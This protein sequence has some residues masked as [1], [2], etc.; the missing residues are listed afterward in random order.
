MRTFRDDAWTPV[1]DRR[2][3]AMLGR[4]ILNKTGDVPSVMYFYN[5]MLYIFR[6]N[7][8]INCFYSDSNGA[9][10]VALLLEVA[11]TQHPSPG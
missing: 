11:T 5:G 3:R 1:T 4:L 6:H 2:L 10:A 9:T 7:V 8:N